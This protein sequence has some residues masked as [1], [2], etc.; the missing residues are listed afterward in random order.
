MLTKEYL[1]EC[2][3]YDLD[4]GNFL[5]KKRPLKHFKSYGWWNCWNRRW[6]GTQAGSFDSKGY[7]MICIDKKVYRSHRLAWFITY[8]EWPRSEIDHID[9]NKRNN[10]INNLREATRSQN[11]LN[12]S[13]TNGKSGIRGVWWNTQNRTWIAR[14]TCNYR[15]IYLG[16]FKN[17]NDAIATRRVAERKYYGEFA[18]S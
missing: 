1:D 10:R 15:T 3:V 18:P 14:I 17:K 11:E 4:T 8:G 7:K 6:S 12:S 5:W 9:R 2:L 16:S 13:V